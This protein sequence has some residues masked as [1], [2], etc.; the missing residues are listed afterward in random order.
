MHTLDLYIQKR[1]TYIL[2]LGLLAFVM[3]FLVVDLVENLDRFIDWKIPAWRVVCYYLYYIPYI[4]LLMLPVAMLL[5]TLFS[6]GDLA[7]YNE[8][9][10]MKASGL[11]L[12]RILWPLFRVAFLISL[13][14]LVFGETVVPEANQ[15]RMG[16]KYSGTRK[17]HQE[18]RRDVFLHESQERIV[19]ADHY[20]NVQQMA[21]GVSIQTYR[22]HALIRRVDADTMVWQQG[23]WMMRGVV[24]RE[25]GDESEQIT[26]YEKWDPELHLT[27]PDFARVQKDPERM[28]YF[29]LAGHIKRVQQIGGQASRWLVDLYMKIAFPFASFVIVLFGAPLASGRKRT[30]KALGFGLSLLICFIYYGFI[31]AGQVLGREAMLPPLLAAWIGNAIFGAMGIFFLVKARK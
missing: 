23:A 20:E 31:K 21:R 2:L 11:S 13:L 5:A 8:L 10:A 29:E 28:G 22:E 6:V 7:K 25:F 12:Y 3:I 17:A 30:G 16:I 1:F 4:L 15:R 26:H 27:P 18:D 19:F 9:V 24:L 14:A